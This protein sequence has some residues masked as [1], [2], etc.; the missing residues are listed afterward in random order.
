MV[1]LVNDLCTNALTLQDEFSK[2]PVNLIII[3][4]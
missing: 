3:E 1:G 4:K 2:I